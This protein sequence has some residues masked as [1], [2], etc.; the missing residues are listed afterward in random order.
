MPDNQ[1]GR[2]AN[3]LWA[4]GWP[5]STFEAENQQAVE[6]SRERKRNPPAFSHV[7]QT[8]KGTISYTQMVGELMVTKLAR[9]TQLSYENPEIQV[10]DTMN[11]AADSI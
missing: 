1:K 9:I 8:Q 11:V 7:E 4:V 10:P 5:N 2:K 3:D 6:G